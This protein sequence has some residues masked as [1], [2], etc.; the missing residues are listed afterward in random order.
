VSGSNHFGSF[1]GNQNVRLKFLNQMGLSSDCIIDIV[2]VTN[3]Y[4]T[5]LGRKTW[6]WSS[7]PV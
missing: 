6:V 5:G 2:G 3:T 7:C 4:G 1:C